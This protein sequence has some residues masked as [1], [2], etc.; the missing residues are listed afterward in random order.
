MHMH[1]LIRH[2]LLPLLLTLTLPSLAATVEELKK[3]IPAPAPSVCMTGL[4][5]GL[6]SMMSKLVAKVA[7]AKK[8]G[9]SGGQWQAGNPQYDK[10]SLRIEQAMKKVQ[11]EQGVLLEVQPYLMLLE[12]LSQSA[13]AETEFFSQA[14][15][16]PEG[17]AFWSQNLEEL[18]CY[19]MIEGLGDAASKTAE[20]SPADRKE[21]FA[22][23][24]A[25]RTQEQVMA[26]FK[27]ALLNAKN[28]LL[29]VEIMNH[30]SAIDFNTHFRRSFDKSKSGLQQKMLAALLPILLDEELNK[31]KV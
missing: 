29:L 22:L 17:R 10:L 23:L 24:P 21:M 30:L 13:P 3:V 6:P 25:P 1:S 7:V 5:K 27:Q 18:L 9:T 20:V 16:D 19:A 12:I 15:K 26:E 8:P 4:N 2:S 11:D 14:L 31:K 28:K